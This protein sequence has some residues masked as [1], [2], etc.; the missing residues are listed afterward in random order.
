MQLTQPRC[1][2]CKKYFSEWDGDYTDH[3]FMCFTCQSVVR[4]AREEIGNI[5]DEEADA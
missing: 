1:C 4:E 3:G 5:N 2:A